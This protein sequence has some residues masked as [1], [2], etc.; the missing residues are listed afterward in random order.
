MTRRNRRK[1]HRCPFYQLFIKTGII[2]NCS[3]PIKNLCNF[4]SYNQGGMRCV[5][6]YEQIG[7]ARMDGEE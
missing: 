3:I 1:I 5:T 7:G 4:C 2:K 6:V